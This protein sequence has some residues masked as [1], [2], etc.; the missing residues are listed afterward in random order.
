MLRAY[1]TGL[2][3][4]DWFTDEGGVWA[5]SLQVRC[6]V[7]RILLMACHVVY[8]HMLPSPQ[9]FYN[10]VS[11]LPRKGLPI[12]QRCFFTMAGG[13]R[14]GGYLGGKNPMM[15]YWYIGFC[16]ISRLVVHELRWGAVT[17]LS[18]LFETRGGDASLLCLSRF[19]IFFLLRPGCL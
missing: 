1:V 13:R 18:I 7:P 4:Y 17:K 8:V 5:R 2:A 15:Q 6:W 14:A 16:A 11:C 19:G 12:L 10:A 3:R 9:F